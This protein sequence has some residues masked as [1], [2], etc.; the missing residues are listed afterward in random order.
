M[1]L[2]TVDYVHVKQMENNRP[3]KQGVFFVFSGNGSV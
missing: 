1:F 3:N 2:F